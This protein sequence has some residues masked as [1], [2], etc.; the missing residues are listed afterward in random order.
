MKKI[1][2]FF[3]LLLTSVSLFAQRE[4]PAVIRIAA[5]V[6]DGQ[7]TII[8]PGENASIRFVKRGDRIF[9]VVISAIEG[10]SLRLEQRED[11]GEL[12]SPY[13][14]PMEDAC[15]GIPQSEPVA[16]A[17]MKLTDIKG[18]IV[19]ILIRHEATLTCRK[20]SGRD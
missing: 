16:V 10:G 12:Q 4:K 1:I 7:N 11:D 8:I 13:G 20:A 9:D 5:E 17:F 18:N 15:F 2:F 19:E 14:E 3:A 6:K